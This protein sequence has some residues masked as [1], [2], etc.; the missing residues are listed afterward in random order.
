MERIMVADDGSEP[1]LAAV[2]LAADLAAKTGAEL[3]AFAAVGSELSP[4][5]IAA[6]A[7]SEAIDEATAREKLAAAAAVYLDRGRDIA[8]R[9]GV[10]RFRAEARIDIDAAAAIVAFARDNGVEL[11]VVGSRGRGRLPGLLLGSVSQ[12]VANEAPC[13]VLIA[14]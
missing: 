3:I 4:R 13:P 1:A 8:A 2:R 11:I 5:D 10:A 7:R 12:K 6:F 14:R 9:L